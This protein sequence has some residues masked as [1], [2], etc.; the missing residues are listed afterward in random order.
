MYAPVQERWALNQ[1]RQV[2]AILVARIISWICALLGL[3]IL[4]SAYMD[5]AENWWTVILRVMG[6]WVFPVLFIIFSSK[7][8]KVVRGAGV[9][10]FLLMILT[11]VAMFLE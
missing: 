5:G 10:A 4:A 11:L 8:R 7:S 3:A 1:E 9:V 6:L 2:A